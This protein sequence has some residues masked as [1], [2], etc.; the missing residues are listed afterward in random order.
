MLRNTSPQ[1]RMTILS[2]IFW[3]VFVTKNPELCD[4]AMEI[5]GWIGWYAIIRIKKPKFVVE[6]GVH[7]RVGALVINF[8]LHRNLNE[9]YPGQYLSTDISPNSGE[10]LVHPFNEKSSIVIDDSI[11]TLQSLVTSI[12]Q[13]LMTV[14]IAQ[15]TRLPSTQVLKRNQV[16]TRWFWEITVTHQTLYADSLKRPKEISYFLKKNPPFNSI[17]ERE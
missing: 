4:S 13:F 8:A 15:N 12:D 11:A 1:S 3:S 5:G 14:T 10:L 9:G 16:W 6:T 17:L 2:K 7:H